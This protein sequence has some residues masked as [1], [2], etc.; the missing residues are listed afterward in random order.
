MDRVSLPY[1]VPV[2]EKR[3]LH[4][5]QRILHGTEL[6]VRIEAAISTDAS[7]SRDMHQLPKTEFI[8]TD[9]EI[10]STTSSEDLH[11]YVRS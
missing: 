1:P 2:G 3:Q 6:P 7:R 11:A 9:K 10:F 4:Q 5:Q 8:T